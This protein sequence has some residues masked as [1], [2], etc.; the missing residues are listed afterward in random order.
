M[1]QVWSFLLS[2]V[3]VLSSGLN[4]RITEADDF[5][6]HA[7]ILGVSKITDM[8]KFELVISVIPIAAIDCKLLIDI[9]I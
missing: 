2:A 1:C 6:T 4:H 9:N 5:Y 8:N 3:L 7:T